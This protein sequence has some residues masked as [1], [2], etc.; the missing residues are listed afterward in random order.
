MAAIAWAPWG[1]VPFCLRQDQ[2]CQIEIILSMFWLVFSVALVRHSDRTPASVAGA[3]DQPRRFFVPSAQP[4]ATMPPPR[5]HLRPVKKGTLKN[6]QDNA[7]P[8]PIH[9]HPSLV[10]RHGRLISTP[11]STQFPIAIDP[12]LA[13]LS[14]SSPE[15]KDPCAYRPR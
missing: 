4:P 8:V 3:D 2:S 11:S 5:A 10:P 7:D 6:E 9:H 13:G 12:R 15:S 14:L 1:S